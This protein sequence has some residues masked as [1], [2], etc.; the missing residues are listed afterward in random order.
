MKNIAK[1]NRFI[2]GIYNYC[3]RWCERCP[4]TS[5]CL[6]YTIVKEEFADPEAR[7]IHNNVFWKNL[8]GI[9]NDT[10]DLIN[11][12][13]AAEGIDLNA[14]DVDESEE[15]DRSV[16]EIADDHE[17]SRAARA[18][19]RITE[20]WFNEAEAFLEK[21]EETDSD[22]MSIA[23]A[24]RVPEDND[25]EDALEVVRWYQHQIYAK[26]VRAISS[27][28]EEDAGISQNPGEEARDSDGSVKVAL[29]GIDRSIG[30]WGIIRN[31]IPCFNKNEIRIIMTHLIKLRRKIETAFP[32]ARIFIRPG[33]DSIDLNS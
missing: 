18:Y 30:A 8:S 6:N 15:K 16:M 20:D 29:I 31:Q 27:R 19:S 17:I 10:L 2:T 5:R 14:L 1:D 4:Q 26:L 23:D 12:K 11:E 3:D 33:F 32:D 25:L 7:D 13:A 9:L 22:T 28:M 24:A 21:S